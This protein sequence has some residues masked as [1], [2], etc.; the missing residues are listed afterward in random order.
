MREPYIYGAISP[1]FLTRTDLQKE[2]FIRAISLA[3]IRIH[4][5]SVLRMVKQG[6]VDEN[7]GPR[8]ENIQG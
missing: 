3:L 4:R 6:K 5:R 8:L 2:C 7:K 1:D